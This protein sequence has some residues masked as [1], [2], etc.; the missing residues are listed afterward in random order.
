MSQD[1]AFDFLSVQDAQRIRQLLTE[2]LARHGMDV[3]ADRDHVRG[4]DGTAYPIRQLM[5]T[6]HRAAQASWPDLADEYAAQLVD[7]G[8][9]DALKALSPDEAKARLVP[10]LV[11]AD[12]PEIVGLPSRLVC[13][14]LAEVL[15]VDLPNS[16]QLLDHSTLETLGGVGSLEEIAFAN[17]RGLPA[18]EPVVLGEEGSALSVRIDESVH[19]ASQALVL[20]EELRRAGAMD[21][22]GC[23]VVVPNRHV[24]A[25]HP[26]QG[27]GALAAINDLVRLAGEYFREAEYPVSADLFWVG[28]NG[29]ERV[30]VVD[31]HTGQIR[32]EV[33][34]HFEKVLLDM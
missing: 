25:W 14:G 6:C 24:L 20:G 18:A 27:S 12:A 17:L 23:L 30:V 9:V 34:S 1:E 7:H 10:H 33:S 21:E 32:M 15:A 26:I 22:R 4:A 28:P 31:R 19:V 11:A 5:A 16:L 29:L 3:V 8:D 2:A 13:A